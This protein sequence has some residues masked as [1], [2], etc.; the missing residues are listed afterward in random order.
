MVAGIN[1]YN[2]Y[3]DRDVSYINTSNFEY[4]SADYYNEFNRSYID[5]EMVNGTRT[6]TNQNTHTYSAY[7]SDVINFSERF[8]AM[9]SLRFDHF[10]DK[11][12]YDC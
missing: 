3:A 1:Y 9:L 11:G 10:N 2:Y 7:L 4:G 5:S 8:L 12:S 6:L